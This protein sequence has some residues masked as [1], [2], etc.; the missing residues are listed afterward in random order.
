MPVDGQ[1][2]IAS[3]GCASSQTPNAHRPLARSGTLFAARI[4]NT[5]CSSAR[6]RWVCAIRRTVDYIKL[7]EFVQELG[8]ADAPLDRLYAAVQLSIFFRGSAPSVARRIYDINHAFERGTVLERCA[9]EVLACGEFV[10][11]LFTPDTFGNHDAIAAWVFGALLAGTHAYIVAASHTFRAALHAPHGVLQQPSPSGIASALRM[12]LTPRELVTWGSLYLPDVRRGEG[13]RWVSCTLVHEGLFHVCSNIG[14]FLMLAIPLERN[15]GTRRLAL[16][17]AYTGI[18]SSLVVGCFERRCD[19]TTGASGI[20]FGLLGVWTS[21][22]II[23]FHTLKKPL[24]R[25]L[26]TAVAFALFTTSGILSGNVSQYAHL[27]GLFTSVIPALLFL[28]RTTAK[29]NVENSIA[30]ACL[31]SAAALTGAMCAYVY[32]YRLRHPFSCVL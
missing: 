21:D 4:L 24:L 6:A 3:A 9:L 25:V 26:A 17:A 32:G 27:G 11:D 29:R 7:S 16:A 1:H 2:S 31:V 8:D 23:N 12:T 10:F 30:V 15:I 28:P 13:Y 22:A 18:S 20:V 5:H 14:M 19:V